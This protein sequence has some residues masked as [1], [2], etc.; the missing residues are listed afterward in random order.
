[1][2]ERVGGSGSILIES[3]EVEGGMGEERRYKFRK[4]KYFRGKKDC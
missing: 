2:L 3:G 1:M 4:R